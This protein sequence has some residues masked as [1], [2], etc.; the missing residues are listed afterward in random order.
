MDV[1]VMVVVSLLIGS[2]VGM[3]VVVALLPPGRIQAMAVRLGAAGLALGA[4]LLA[5]GSP[6][7]TARTL[8]VPGHAAALAAFGLDVL[9]SVLVAWFALRAR[10][11]LPLALA[12]VQLALLAFV[13]FGG[14]HAAAAPHVVL[15]DGLSSIMVLIIGVIGGLINIHAVGYM[16][17]YHAHHSEVK[18]R[19]GLF[20][21]LFF[22]FEAAMVGVVCVD[23]LPWLFVCWEVTTLCSF[24]LIGYDGSAQARENAF[25][26][27]NLNLLGGIG[28]AGALAA[29]SHSGAAPLLSVLG[30]AAPA[31]AV[32]PAALIA[33]AGLTKS[34]QMPFSSW[35][36]GAMVAPSPVSALLHSST[37]V[38]AGVFV[39]IRLSPAL[40]GTAAGAVLALIGA[41]TFALASLIAVSQNNAKR[42]LAYSTI[43]NLGLIVACAGAG[44]AQALWAAVL[45]LVFHAVSKALLFLAVGTVEH[46]IESR[47]I[48]DMGGLIARCRPEA[49]AIL[50][51]MAGMFL[52]PF[53]MLIS[54]W[55]AMEA[56]IRVSP[57]LPILVAFGS[58]ATLFFWTKWMGK[59]LMAVAEPE[60][61]HGRTGADER[62]VLAALALLTIAL[63]A[64]FPLLSSSVI[65][66]WLAGLFQGATAELGLRMLAVMAVMLVIVLLLPLTLLTSRA[67]HR[68]V[69][70]PHYG[71][72]NVPAAGRFTAAIGE[73]R[74]VAFRNYYLATYFS[75]QRLGRPALWIGV[76]LVLV[77]IGSAW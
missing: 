60:P 53:G 49:L 55:A 48:E 70:P 7:A 57:L 50:I 34:A 33:F 23:Y 42:V 59:L 8:G 20:F 38:K 77:M 51:G 44:G 39:I 28:F 3:A 13:E 67:P 66:P 40:Q 75:E 65:N 64:G 16:R 56:L 4:V 2:A 52:A 68:R 30:A 18:D 27:L 47:D 72:A 25:R 29:Q 24:L 32:L 14:A 71:G 54:K 12:G 37:M 1:E 45:L 22:L 26:A 74:P 63:C 69:V 9:L 36:L 73:P 17:D 21:G 31:A 15:L 76:V 46:R 6:V 10:R 58:A 41:V 35:L 11:L 43:A 5:L 62:L 19:R 61:I